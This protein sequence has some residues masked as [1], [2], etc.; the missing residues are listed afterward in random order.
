MQ[1]SKQFKYISFSIGFAFVIT[2]VWSAAPRTRSIRT[3]DFVFLPPDSTKL[4]S[5]KANL[6]Y[7]IKDRKPYELYNKKHPLDLSEPANIKNKWVL[8]P[9]TY[10]YNY[11][12]KV[13]NQDYRLPSSSSINNRLEQDG[14]RNNAEYFRQRSQAQ[15]FVRGGGI[16]PQINLGNKV[17]DRI[18]GSGVIDIRPRGTAELIF[19][20][21]F[22]TVRNPAFSLRQQSTGQ[23]D[24][25]QKIQLNVTGSIGDK[26]RVNMNYDTEATFEFENQMK[27]DYAGKEDDIIKKIELGNVS[28]PLNSALINGSQSLFGV[29]STMQFGK[30]Q[31]TAVVSQQRGKTQETELSGGAMQTKFDIQCDNYDMNR[32][33][34]LAHYF[35]DN[36]DRWLANLPVIGSPV[37]ITQVEVWV[38]NRSG[39]FE[40]SRDVMAFADLGE[41]SRRENKFWQLGA[42][43]TLG[44][45][46]NGL[47]NYLNGAN[48]QN[49]QSSYAIQNQLMADAPVTGIKPI[50]EYQIVNFA[51]QLGPNEFTFNPRLGYISLNQA[52]NNDDVLSVAFT[53]FI[54]GVPFTVG[55]L[56]NA[57]PVNPTTP[58]VLWLKMLKGPSLRPDLAQWDL[59]MKNI[60]SLGSFQVQQKDFKLNIVYADDPSGADLNYIPARNEPALSGQPLLT[61]L[62]LDNLN[63]QQERAP[64]GV[65]DYIENVTINSQTGRIIFPVVEPFGAYLQSKFVDKNLAE[66]YGFPQ[67][68]DSTRFSAV[69]LPQFN[70]FFLRGTY[71]GSSTNEISLGATNVPRGSVR[72]TANGAPLTENADFIVDYN[73][74]RVKIVNTALLNSGAVIKVSSESNNLFQIQQRSLIGARFD[75]KLNRD[76]ILGS[77]FMFMN[78]RPLTPKVNIGEEPI[79]NIVVGL[80]GT[81][82]KDSRFLT[83]MIDKLPLIETKEMSQI[84][85]SGEY[86]RL[87]PGVQGAL[88]QNGTAYLDDFEGAETPFDL[89][90]GNQWSL[91][92]TPQ[93]QPDLF[94]EGNEFNNLAYGSKRA[95]LAWY[96]IATTFYRNDAFTPQHL[97]D[98]PNVLSNHRVRE[99]LQQD[100]FPSK[101]IQ[102]GLPTTL[103]TFDLAFFPRERGPYNYNVTD[104]LNDG[105][106]ANPRNN[107]GGIMRKVD[108]NDFEQAN[109][110]YIEIWLMDPF[111]DKPASN[112]KGFLYLNLGNISEDILRDNRRSAENGL[113]RNKTPEQQATV[114]TTA[115]GKVP[116]LPVINYAFDAE[117]TARQNQD[118]GLDGL[119][120]EEERNYF[121]TRYLSAVQNKFGSN[122]PAYQ[123]AQTDPSNDNYH[124]YLGTDYDGQKL[125]VLNRYK[126]F[127]MHQGNSPTVDQSPEAYPTAATNIPD[128]EDLNRDF[129]INDIEEYYQYKIEISRDAFTVGKNY[130]TDTLTTNARFINGN[131]APEKWYQL[132][133]PVREFEKRVGNISDFKSIRFIRMFVKGFEEE[134][135]LRFATLQLV[136][137]DWRKYLNSLEAGGEHKPIDPTDNTQFVVSTVNIEKNSQRVPIRYTIPPGIQ[138]EIDFSSPNAIQQNE[139][140]ISLLTC[141]L[142]DGDA[143]AVFK[144][145]SVDLRLYGKLRMFVHAEGADVKNGEVT[146]FIRV[147]TDL[148]NN[149]YEYEIPLTITPAN[150]SDPS[151]IWP[152]ENEMIIQLE[153][154]VN[155]KIARTNANWPFTSPFTR[156]VGNARITVVG[157]PDF[158]QARVLMLGVRNPKRL[159]GSTGDD[160]LPKCTE[161]WFNELRMTE[162]ST[163]G[164]D[165][166]TGR[167]QAKLADLG[168]M[169]LSGT[170]TS[171]GWGGVDKKLLERSLSDNYQYDLQTNF[172]LGRFLPKTTGISIPFFFSYGNTLI[173]PFYNPLNPDTRL[174]KELDETNNEERVQ[175]I[176]RASDDYTARKS[177]N[178]TNVRKNRVGAKQ[179]HLWDIENFSF[180]YSFNEIF[181]RNQTLEYSF[182]QNYK[183]MVMYN[184]NFVNKPWEPFK[185]IKNQHLTL[186]KDF[187]L[188]YLPASWG[189]RVEADRRYGETVNRNNDNIQT[190][191]PVLYDKMFTM[192]RNYEFRYD[193]TRN[194]K[195]DYNATADARIDEPLG[196]IADDTPEKRDSIRQNFFNGGRIMKFDQTNRINYNIPINKIPYLNFIS[197][198]SYMYTVNYQWLQA[199]PAADSL[200]NTIQ[201]SVQSQWN[202][203]VSMLSLYNKF[204]LFRDINN[205]AA[206]A[207]QPQPKNEKAKGKDKQDNAP[208]GKKPWFV[209]LPVKL[210]TSL[211]NINGNYSTTNGAMLPGFQPKPQYLGQNFDLGAPGFDFIF[212]LQSDDYRFKAARNGW[213]SNDTRI[214]NPYVK[215]YQENI[216]GRA[217]IEPW[218][219]LRLELNVNKTYSRTLS[220][221]FRYDDVINDFRDF[222][223]PI[224]NGSY[225]IS[226]STVRTAFS[227][228]NADG[229]SQVFRQFEANRLTIANR[230]AA[231]KGI[232][233]RDSSGFPVGYGAYQQDVL[234]SS[235]LSAYSGKDP[236]GFNITPFP[237]IPIP[238]WRLTYNGLTRYA[239]V[240][241]YF[242]NV[243]IQHAYQSTYNVASF[244]TLADTARNIAV[245][246]D[247]QP[248]ILIRQISLVE[249]FGPLIGVEVTLVNNVT[250][251]VK[252]NQDRTMNFSLGNRQLSEQQG[253]EFVFGLGYR[254]TKLVLPFKIRGRRGVLEND[255]NF[256]LDFSIRE[257]VTKIRYL[258]RI[259]N[260]PVLGQTVYSLRPNIDYMIN[261]KLMLRIFYDRR[262]T[263]PFTSNSFPTIITSGGFSLR[264][265]IQ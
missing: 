159:P 25:R 76:V 115:W 17:I 247:I 160:G 161:V 122:S 116:K 95:N 258:D 174:Q 243:S 260:D 10:Q 72:V 94:P 23:F 223:V 232:S 70:K 107:W 68:Y 198:F 173:R 91:A 138:R 30:L 101:Q 135:V 233:V 105:T 38:T 201:N 81:I 188:N 228:E 134:T 73:L 62:N 75:Y 219:D 221:Y 143:R 151:A 210:I 19:Q 45:Q 185:N 216:T 226:Y 8:D 178:F 187:N 130:V 224:E 206:P 231:D 77:T 199:P 127:N 154:L 69:Q 140:S 3:R 26:L 155:T 66:Y 262:Q 164:G 53:G 46:V 227:A 264:Y 190:I 12:S 110:D 84:T 172:E 183:G 239:I 35:R 125:D 104:L 82:K 177:F 128:N 121:E 34:F 126:R 89:R 86:A 195:Y 33:Y 146:A 111:A 169:Q 80:D 253:K 193:I 42:D 248:D 184:Y 87:I 137:A 102:Q 43:T 230:I 244:Q 92:S 153:E 48:T 74:G 240:K 40:N 181:R 265:T 165:A 37:V 118:I 246:T 79:S 7:P 145:T 21:N 142:K 36:Y 139:Q 67:L 85:F 254:T 194:L 211:K 50:S 191:T 114:D 56:S 90:M 100:V 245:S 163:R 171:V 64:D 214:V 197:Q 97:R 176:S 157:L 88:A 242:S 249:R 141:N 108:Q 208:A 236:A 98:D 124:Y 250:G 14:K 149:Y 31:V 162:F 148:T 51:R 256:R 152:S 238:N 44:N 32:H 93:G 186:I 225:S 2:M 170:Y 150:A 213:M 54:N 251:S 255:I 200:G 18:F 257:N 131:Y 39:S 189:M 113:P 167:L 106:L 204:K 63:T 59:M 196:R 103:P 235:F 11:S 261:E 156:Q 41:A 212:G 119:D 158:S 57:V 192:R 234:I 99:V 9:E 13:G 241:E 237:Q 58:N 29:K 259:S 252:Y 52:L 5:P 168:N 229:V 136:R 222:G 133:I 71:Q 144:N 123:A 132:K 207:P 28:L 55:Q 47:W 1:R 27:L 6:P 24:F 109:I 147:G 96:T 218:D 129:T 179:A 217:T 209:V 78:E 263:N 166:A 120:D 215:N 175:Q 65:F 61:V 15:N 202:I 112:D 220:A 22:N 205:P 60:Y 4:D 49:L 117:P 203:N 83:K 16:I 182:L 180:T 20:G